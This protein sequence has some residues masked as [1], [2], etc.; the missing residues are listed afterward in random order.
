M[1]I[2]C[3]KTMHCAARRFSGV[4]PVLWSRGVHLNV[5]KGEATQS[6]NEA[7]FP[8]VSS[9]EHLGDSRYD[10]VREATGSRLVCRF[11]IFQYASSK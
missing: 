1:Y 6:Q 5:A 7:F 10:H 4:F 8:D 2:M 11:Y 9:T 3:S